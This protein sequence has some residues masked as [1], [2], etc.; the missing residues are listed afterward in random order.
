[1]RNVIIFDGNPKFFLG[2]GQVVTLSV[3][4]ALQS[5]YHVHLIEMGRTPVFYRKAESYFKS[6]LRLDFPSQTTDS[7]QSSYNVSWLEVLFFPFYFIIGFIR[8]FIFLLKFDSSDTIL[9]TA[10]KKSHLLVYFLN[11]IFNYKVIAH[12]HTVDSK[13]A[14]FFKIQKIVYQKFTTVLMPSTFMHEHFSLSNSITIENSTQIP[15]YFHK[16]YRGE[17]FRVGCI[18]SLTLIKGI[19]YFIESYD[20]LSPS[21]DVKY[22]I[23]GTGR[24]MKRLKALAKPD[25]HFLGHIDE[26]NQFYNNVDL[27]V[28]PSIVPEA[29]GLV[30]IEAFVRGIPVVTTNIGAQAE[31]LERIQMDIGVPCMDAKAIAAR[32]ERFSDDFDYYTKKSEMVRKNA[33][34]FSSE[35]FDIKINN[36]FNNCLCS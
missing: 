13:E 15:D 10:S 33:K 14:L 1:M 23:A 25:I 27:V 7:K 12:A 11:M 31:L 9:Y 20:K 21:K 36:I 18:S 19:E 28:L 3:M 17:P 16:R 35:C 26:K 5:S 8:T 24:E 32:V 4:Q 22:I 30:I 6:S 29:F 2:G 34:V